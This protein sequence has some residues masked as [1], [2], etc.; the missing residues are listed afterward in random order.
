MKHAEGALYR[1]NK[2]LFHNPISEQKNNERKTILRLGIG[3]W[4]VDLNFEGKK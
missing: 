1:A 4:T 3:V 2:E